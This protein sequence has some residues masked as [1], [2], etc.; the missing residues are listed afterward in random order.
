VPPEDERLLRRERPP[1]NQRGRDYQ[2]GVLIWHNSI[3]FIAAAPRF[4]A[5]R[6]GVLSYFHR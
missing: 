2:A 4:D 5:G 6:R 3:E 1:P